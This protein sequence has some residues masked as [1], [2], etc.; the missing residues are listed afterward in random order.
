MSKPTN[1]NENKRTAG[2]QLPDSPADNS[3]RSLLKGAGLG[4][5]LIGA[6]VAGPSSTLIAQE[7]NSSESSARELEALEVLTAVEAEVL[8]ALCDVLIPSDDNGPGAREARA[9]HYIDRA[10]GAHNEEFREDYFVSLNAIN[11][12]AQRTYNNVF[13]DLQ[14][15]QQ[16]AVVAA[17]QND[18]V[19]GCSPGSAAFFSLVRSHTIDGTF[20]DPYYGGNRD[21]VGWDLLR[22]PGVRLSASADDVAAGASL[23]PTH[24]SAYDNSSYTKDPGSGTQSGGRSAS[25][26]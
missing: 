14:A 13:A 15:S 11:E 1:K 18:E 24:Q 12:H 26:D 17:L 23:L 16:N 9:A 25:D 7:S 19:S 6:A 4:A 21:F 10:L 22:Y 8:E 2:K 3:R 5:G 20:C